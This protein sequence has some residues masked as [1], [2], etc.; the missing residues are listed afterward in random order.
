MTPR[1]RKKSNAGL[2]ENLYPSSKA[3]RVS[4]VYRH[5]VKKTRHGMGTDRAKAIQ[6]AKQLNS[7][8]MPDNDLVSK[9]VGVVTIDQ[10][11]SWFEREIM[12][13]RKYAAKTVELYKTKFNQIKAEIGAEKPVDEVTVKDIADAMERLTDRSAQQFRQVAVDLFRTAAGRG[14]IE[15]NPAELTNKPV[16]EKT[17][18]RLTREQFDAVREAAPLWLQNAMDLAIITLQRREDIALMKFEQ[19]NKDEK[20]LYVIQHKTKKHDTGYLKISI[21]RELDAVLARCRDDIASP[22]LV[23]RDPARRIRREGLH[24]SQIR[25]EFITRAFKEITDE[26]E[27]FESI[28]RTA[29]PTFHE[30]RALGIKE[31]KDKGA[32]PQLLAGHASAKMTKNYD[33]GH[34]EIRWIEAETI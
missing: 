22:F 16:A 7:L 30:I 26:L 21:G 20:A 1:P 11:I 25:P 24:W 17:R 13:K 12:P 3:G 8:L 18:Q 5:P 19:I 32:N 34:D 9:V 2:P 23:H 27:I 28:P 31:Y 33:A 4:F 14:L 10:H 6:A 29:R 15:T